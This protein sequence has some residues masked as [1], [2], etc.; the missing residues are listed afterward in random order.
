[1]TLTYLDHRLVLGEDYSLQDSQSGRAPGLS[2]VHGE[3]AT[4]VSRFA[5]EP[6]P[7]D[8]SALV[9]KTTADSPTSTV[10][11]LA[12]GDSVIECGSGASGPL[13]SRKI[14]I[15]PCCFVLVPLHMQLSRRS[16]HVWPSRLVP[17]A[18]YGST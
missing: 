12:K 9:T 10:N 7:Y 17:K 1:M 15:T 2:D 3:T 13:N 11:C 6:H 8:P 18:S 4:Q 14:L 16:Q 5:A